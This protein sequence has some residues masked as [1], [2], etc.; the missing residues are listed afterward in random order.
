M[1]ITLWAPLSLQNKLILAMALMLLPLVLLGVGSFTLLKNTNTA[2]SSVLRETTDSFQ[3]IMHLQTAVLEAVNAPHHYLIY[4]DATERALFVDLSQEVGMA[5]TDITTSNLPVNKLA[6]VI[7]AE[8]EWQQVRIL[9]ELIL[10]L[11][12]PI[13]QPISLEW[14]EDYHHHVG[15]I[16]DLLNQLHTLA[17]EKVDAAHAQASSVSLWTKV[18]RWSNYCPKRLLMGSCRT[19]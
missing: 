10:S 5:F 12:Q 17:V 9:G 4:G 3:P 2:L 1:R 8:Q 19:I 18:L 11:P 13:Q 15:L 14:M 16:T 7:S 6:I